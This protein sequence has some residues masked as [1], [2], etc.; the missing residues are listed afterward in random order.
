MSLYQGCTDVF[1]Y[2]DLVGIDTP[3]TANRWHFTL[4][5]VEPFTGQRSDFIP[6]YWLFVSLA[7]L[8]L[9]PH[10][11]C[12]LVTDKQ[13]CPEQTIFGDML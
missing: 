13:N 7:E 6:G 3:P 10:V 12:Y 1:Y 4:T 8:A 2:Y 11:L 9:I 5:K